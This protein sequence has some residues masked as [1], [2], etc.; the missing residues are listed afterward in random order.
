[1]TPPEPLPRV[2]RLALA[3]LCGMVLLLAACGET[4]PSAT[5]SVLPSAAASGAAA[6]SAAPLPEVEL[7]G[8]ISADAYRQHLDALQRIADE[9]DGVRTVGTPGYQASVEYAIVQLQSFGYHVTTP[10]FPMP[11][12]RELPGST[13]EVQGYGTAFAAP[14]EFKAMIFAASGALSAAVATVGYPGSPGGEGRQGCAADDWAGFPDGAIAL[15]PPGPCYRRDEAILAQE[16]GAVALIV[17]YPDREVGEV[18]RPTLIRP[19]EIRIPVISAAGTVGDALAKASDADTEV[20]VRV[21]TEIEQATVRNVI[22]EWEGSADRVV[23]IGAHLDSV[24]DGPGINDNGS[25]TAAVLEIARLLAGGEEPATFR[26]ALWAGEELGLYGSGSY[27][28]GLNSGERRAIAAYLNLDMLG[29]MNGVPFVYRDAAAAP[30]SKAIGDFLAGWLRAN[31]SGAEFE[32]LGGGSDHYFFEEAAI[33]T[34]GIFSGATEVKS[35]AQAS[36]HGGQADEPMDACY[37]LACDRADNVDVE[38]AV[39]YAT[40]AASVMLLIARGELPPES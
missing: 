31:G 27:V 6:G 32:D 26:F 5:A 1:M 8:E 40:D 25:G 9:N 37:H 22:A 2:P 34:G 36:A 30:G 11:T 14:D 18:L 17:A 20:H 28:S 12:F 4:A 23:M 3:A 16:A 19:D 38:R 29:S 39:L 15:T 10:T 13:I 33:P 35:P 21:R 7:P 24:H